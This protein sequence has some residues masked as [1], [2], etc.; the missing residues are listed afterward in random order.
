MVAWF[1]VRGWRVPSTTALSVDALAP[2]ERVLNLSL[3]GS[4]GQISQARELQESD[5]RLLREPRRLPTLMSGGPINQVEKLGK[6][7]NVSPNQNGSCDYSLDKVP[8]HFPL[9][10]FHPRKEGSYGEPRGKAIRRSFLEM[11]P[12]VRIVH[13]NLWPV[14]ELR[15]RRQDFY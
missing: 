5:L 12:A 6:F 3:L 7:N 11:V 14:T 4:H 15:R 1:F 13:R 8:R 2:F 10:P 9:Y